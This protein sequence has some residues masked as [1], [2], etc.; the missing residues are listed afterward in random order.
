MALLFFAKGAPDLSSEYPLVA[1]GSLGFRILQ[2]ALQDVAAAASQRELDLTVDDRVHETHP[3]SRRRRLLELEQA[4]AQAL[5]GQSSEPL[6]TSLGAL[7][8]GVL[9]A[10]ATLTQ[11]REQYPDDGERLH[12]SIEAYRSVLAGLSHMQR[13]FDTRL[14]DDLESGLAET[15]EATTLVDELASPPRETPVQP[16][17]LRL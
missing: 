5:A 9:E 17:D 16:L 6:R 15:V 4:A 11:A 1:S 2:K 13:Y 14:D 7:S 3:H 12:T 8:A 10:I